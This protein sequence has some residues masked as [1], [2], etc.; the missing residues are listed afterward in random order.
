MIPLKIL[1]HADWGEGKSW[2]GQTTPAPRLVIDA[3]G[4]SEFA[5]GRKIIWENPNDPPPAYDG[6]W[7][8]CIVRVQKMRDL[9]TI[10]QWLQRG[11]HP[12]V[13]VT[14][15]SLSEM[16]KR[17][18]DEIAG[19]EQLAP[20]DWGAVFRKGEALVRSFRDLVHNPAK[21]ILCICY[22]TGTVERGRA[23]V[24]VS[25]YV[26]GQL[27]STLPGFV[28]ILGYL[29]TEDTEQGERRLLQVHQQRG[30]T[31][32]FDERNRRKE[33]P[34]KLLAKDRT[35][36]FHEGFVDVTYDNQTGQWANTIESM[37]AR[38]TTTVEAREA[39]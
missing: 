38:I 17:I 11:L 37:M 27:G 22:L 34:W 23:E 39:V 16:Q 14:L 30:K 21:P 19:L 24:K 4:G 7:D 15:D 8:T 12:F 31:E 18:V 26:Q 9:Q 3:E 29:H 28:D 10:F 33:V 5:I 2:L 1:V 32:Q 25:P 36:T 35:H 6:T 13:S 20:Q